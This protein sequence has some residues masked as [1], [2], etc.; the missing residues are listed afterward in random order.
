[1]SLSQTENLNVSLHR[2]R[3]VAVICVV[4]GHAFLVESLM[5]GIKDLAPIYMAI[6]SGTALFVLLAG[7]IFSQ[8]A[9]PKLA[10]GRLTTALIL[11]RRFSELMPI[12]LTAGTYFALVITL[13]GIDPKIHEVGEWQYFIRMMLSG[14]MALSYWYVPFFLLLMAFTPMHRW[15]VRQGPHLKAFLILIG[16]MLS[17]VLHR[18][19]TENVFAAAHSLSYYLPIFWTG[20]IIGENWK[21]FLD[22]IR[23][24]MPILTIALLAVGVLQYQIGNHTVMLDDTPDFDRLDL[25]SLQKMLAAFLLIAIFER[26]KHLAMPVLDWLADHSLSIFFMHPIVLILF[27]DLPHWSGIYIP[28]TVLI[29]ILIIFVGVW[30]ESAARR[31][32]GQLRRRL[33]I[34]KS[35]RGSIT[36]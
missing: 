22:W 16:L 36:H 23:Q 7:I 18:P 11:R 30:I 35:C 34:S 8:K 19:S 27:Y 21:R 10:D 2:L 13:K 9:L 33:Q 6:A 24:A 32:T 15:F 14:S 31:V 25:F 29:S 5:P 12:Y 1:M 4:F 17:M 3:A 20:L 26:S 28:E